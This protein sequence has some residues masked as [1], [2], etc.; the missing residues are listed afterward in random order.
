LDERKYNEVSVPNTL[1][2][3]RWE[4]NSPSWF[5]LE[6]RSEDYSSS[7]AKSSSSSEED[8]AQS[9]IGGDDER[10]ENNV[11][12]KIESDAESDTDEIFSSCPRESL[13]EENTRKRKASSKKQGP[14]ASGSKDTATKQ[15]NTQHAR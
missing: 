6:D 5:H 8:E 14:K 7:E 1:G 12:V 10:S 3:R 11:H 13:D 2:R 15:H 9:P 4:K